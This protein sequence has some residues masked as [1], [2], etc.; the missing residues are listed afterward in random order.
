[1]EYEIETTLVLST[2]HITEEDSKKLSDHI[3]VGDKIPSL[4]IYP[5]PYGYIVNVFEKIENV[6]ELSEGFNKAMKLAIKLK[7]NYLKFD[8]DGSAYDTE[9]LNYCEW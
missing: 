4:S 8:C 6:N 1:M 7:V 5:Y 3:N 9:E 2:A